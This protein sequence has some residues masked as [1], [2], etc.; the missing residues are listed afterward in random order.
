[1]VTDSKDAALAAV[2]T[3]IRAHRGLSRVLAIMSLAA[4]AGLQV[5]LL[6]VRFQ[7]FTFRD[8]FTGFN[9]LG[10][11][12]GWALILSSSGAL[13]GAL[14]WR[15]DPRSWL[16]RSAFGLNLVLLAFPLWLMAKMSGWF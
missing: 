9:A 1:M 11:V 7:V 6:L 13:L 14:A 8:D 3:P 2:A 12:I 15:A 10:F 5:L 16:A 4:V